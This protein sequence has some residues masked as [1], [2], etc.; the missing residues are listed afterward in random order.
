MADIRRTLSGEILRKLQHQDSE[1]FSAMMED[2]ERAFLG[3]F[4]LAKRWPGKYRVERK[5][6]MEGMYLRLKLIEIETGE[7][8]GPE[9][10]VGPRGEKSIA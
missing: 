7:Q 2:V 3:M 6:F 5:S 8:V 4:Y 9:L 1:A 10:E